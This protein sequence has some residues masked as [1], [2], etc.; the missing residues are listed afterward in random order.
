MPHLQ[1]LFFH[2]TRS[3][4]MTPQYC[5]DVHDHPN[6]KQVGVKLQLEVGLIFMHDLPQ[7]WTGSEEWHITPSMCMFSW[8]HKFH[9]PVWG[10]WNGLWISFKSKG[11]ALT[12]ICMWTLYAQLAGVNFNLLLSQNGIMLEFCRITS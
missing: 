7:S 8:G 4:G 5:N 9:M 12:S 2:S 11:C 1:V 6:A 3:S 10:H